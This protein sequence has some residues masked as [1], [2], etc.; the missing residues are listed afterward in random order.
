MSGDVAST[1]DVEIHSDIS[2]KMFPSEGNEREKME[3][4]DTTLTSL[5]GSENKLENN[6][7]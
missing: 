7:Y 6:G 1:H 2:G 5:A 4:L 3:I